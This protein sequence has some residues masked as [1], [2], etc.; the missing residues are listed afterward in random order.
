[1]YSPLRINHKR[2]TNPLMVKQQT[3]GQTYG[4]VGW[5]YLTKIRTVDKHLILLLRY[6]EVGIF[7]QV[8]FYK[9]VKQHSFYNPAQL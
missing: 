7:S 6:L 2:L 4:W 1:M 3:Y 8:S 9:K 5:V